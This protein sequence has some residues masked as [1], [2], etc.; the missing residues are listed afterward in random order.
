VSD[1]SVEA[2]GVSNSVV[3]TGDGNNV[4]LSFGDTGVRLQLL[5]KQFPSPERH[6]RPREREPPRELDLLVP[7][8]GKLPLIGRK[9]LFAELQAW[10]DHEVDISVWD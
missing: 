2:R 7:E 5:R 3:V 1:R 10:L 4:A 6:R 9:D 8:A